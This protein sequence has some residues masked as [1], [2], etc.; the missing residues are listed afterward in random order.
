[1][2]TEWKLVPV[3]PT[4]EMNRAGM[5]WLTGI[6][7]MRAGDRRNALNEAFKAMLAAAPQPPAGEPE[8]RQ[9]L[10]Y[11][12]EDEL[13]ANGLGY[14]I[15]KVDA[16]KLHYAGFRSPVITVLEVWEAIGHDITRNPDKQELFESLRFMTEICEAHGNDMPAPQPPVGGEPSARVIHAILNCGITHLEDGRKVVSLDAVERALE[17]NTSAYTTLDAELDT[18]KQALFQAQE[19]AKALA[20]E[21]DALQSELTKA[22]EWAV[23]RWKDE[24]SQRPLQNIHRRSFDDTWRQVIT[25]LGG[26]HR[27]LCGPTHDELL[28]HKSAP[29]DTGGN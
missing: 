4:D 21:R 14:P 3:E 26:D 1:M 24:V 7:H 10:E 17:T 18:A 8:A 27:E 22:R 6:Q 28:A 13:I 29:A 12:S 25:R 23:E 19:A 16:V 20:A 9:G 5:R 11:P 15:S 2:S